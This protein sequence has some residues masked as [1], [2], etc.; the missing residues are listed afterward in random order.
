MKTMTIREA[1]G[2]AMQEEMERDPKV[3]LMGEEVAE[4]DGAYKV[5]R[6]LLKTFGPKRVID[7]PI[8]EGGF[9]GVGVGAAMAG[10]R[11]IVEMMTWNFAIQAFDQII[12]H[13]AKMNYMSG[14]QFP[15]P[16]VFRGP[17]GAAHMLSA[18]HSQNLDPLLT[19]VP[20]LKVISVANPSDA[21][22]LLKSAIRDNNP[23]VFLESEMLYALKGEVPEGEHLIPIGQGKLC[24]EGNDVTIVSWGKI[25]R[26]A[27]EAVSQLA[28]QGVSCDLIDLRTLVPMDEALV[29]AS[30]RKTHR[31]VIVEENWPFASV[32]AQIS[33]RI[34]HECFDD[35]DA[36][37]ERVS[38]EPVPVPYSEGLEHLALPSVDKIL[39]AVKRVTYKS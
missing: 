18:Q 32:G 14:G 28:E 29:F 5:S 23:V 6:G 25:S 20:G 16:I 27:I 3:F 13:A 24:Q 10:L 11:P 7:T 38:Q 33:D 8:S 34:Q 30:V 31:A 39:A 22:G 4:Y 19:N 37:V 21:K 35:L 15:V 12:N 2:E 17:N 36:P 9:A 26:V 1:L